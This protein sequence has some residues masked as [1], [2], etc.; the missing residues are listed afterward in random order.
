MAPWRGD[1]YR[2]DMYAGLSSSDLTSNELWIGDADDIT[3][4][5][6]GSPSST[7]IQIS[8]ASGGHEAQGGP[9]QIPETS[10]SAETQI[11]DPGPDVLSITA[12]ARWLR[13]IRSETTEAVLNW[14]MK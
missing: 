5:L 3:V 10:W 8:N 4:F 2:T 14:K 9:V 7:T 11:V 1:S 6:R 12:G 13:S